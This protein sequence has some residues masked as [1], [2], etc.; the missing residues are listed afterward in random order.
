MARRGKPSGSARELLFFLRQRLLFLFDGKVTTDIEIRLA[1]IAT[2]VEHLKGAKTFA[3]GFQLA[4][5]LD[6]P[7]ACRVNAELTQ[8]GGNPLSP[9]LFRHGGRGAAS[10]EEIGHQIAFVAA[11]FNKT[12]Q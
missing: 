12:F 4:L 11:G 9:Q 7:L 3:G 2:K 5:D 6:E 8:V 1:F 10:A